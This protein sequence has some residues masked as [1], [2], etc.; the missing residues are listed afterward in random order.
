MRLTLPIHDILPATPRACI[1]RLDLGGRS[2]DYVAGQ[3]VLVAA[4]GQSDA[5]PFSIAASPE[6]ARRTGWLELLIG[7]DAN[8]IPSGPLTLERGAPIDVEGPV[9]SFV[10]PANPEERR[11]VFI[12]GG[13]GIAPLRAMLGH[14]LEMPHD[15]I[16]VFYSARTPD[17][18]AYEQEL[19]ELAGRG[20]ISL[21]RKV[22]RA[23]DIEHWTGARGRIGRGDLQGLVHDPATLCFI[24][25]PP[26]LV[27]E[28][29][30]IL[31][32]LEVAPQ[33]IRT[34]EWT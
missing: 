14:A 27:K 1:L 33:R 10:F 29:T 15:E 23:D 28:M 19:S 11:F 24:C 8:G 18:F 34:E 12:A 17:E 30:A 5:K 7:L 26:G 6:E 13:T 31:R 2:F 16:G 20:E 25:G 22:T 9:G 4:H 21:V 3:A 32:G